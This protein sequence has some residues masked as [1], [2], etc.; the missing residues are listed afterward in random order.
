MMLGEAD[1]G[2]T[3]RAVPVALGRRPSRGAVRS[4]SRSGPAPEGS[5][6]A[7]AR[8]GGRRPIAPG[9]EEA[10]GQENRWDHTRVQQPDCW[11]AGRRRPT[12]GLLAGTGE[13]D[14]Y[15][16]RDFPLSGR[17]SAWANEVL[18]AVPLRGIGFYL[19]KYLDRAARRDSGKVRDVSGLG[20]R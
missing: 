14:D 8:L 7:P 11:E 6:R 17:L 12:P 3:R 1:R 19:D 16:G 5:P 4:R 10:P 9:G 15:T 20:G 18:V 13:Q 2:Q